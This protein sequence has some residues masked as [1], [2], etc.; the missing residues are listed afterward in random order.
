MKRSRRFELRIYWEDEITVEVRYFPTRE[1]A[2]MYATRNGA[3]DYNIYD[4]KSG[5]SRV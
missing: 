3:E 2:E 4:L 5:N 1:D